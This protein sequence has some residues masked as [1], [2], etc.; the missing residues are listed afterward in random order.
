MNFK[1]T[2]ILQFRYNGIIV[3]IQIIY[4]IQKIYWNNFQVCVLTKIHGLSVFGFGL[5][6]T[7]ELES[8]KPKPI[9][10]LFATE[11]DSKYFDKRNRK[12]PTETEAD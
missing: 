4:M 1:V 7:T 2:E 8:H 3:G 6:S 12:S 9:Q 5:E 11:T 10:N